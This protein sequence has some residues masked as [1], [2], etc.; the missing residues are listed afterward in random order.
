MTQ[1]ITNTPIVLPNGELF[2]WNFNGFGSGY[3]QTQLMDSFANMI[4]ILTCLS[5]LG[6]NIE[7][8]GF[9]IRV[10]GDDSIIAFFEMIY[11]IYGPTF[12]TKLEET[13]LFYFNAKLNVKKSEI[14]SCLSGLTVLGY[15]NAY[16][17]P[18]RNDVDLL[19]H[20]FYPEH[21]QDFTRTL[22]AAIGLGFAA[23][24]SSERF[25]K[26]CE[27]IIQDLEDQ[28]YS[29]HP[30]ILAKVMR[31]VSI[32]DPAFVPPTSLPPRIELLGSVACPQHRTQAQKDMLWPTHPGPHNRFYFLK[33]L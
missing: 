1:S 10:Q 8:K 21:N 11:Q 31:A 3:Q 28:G 22:A 19:K 18:R 9:W 25:H 27:L 29:P 14:S 5:A 23:S 33:E 24:G 13:A 2:K 20:L 4:M 7:A 12:L 17:M 32:H 16:G 6:I 26:L 30:R 15:F